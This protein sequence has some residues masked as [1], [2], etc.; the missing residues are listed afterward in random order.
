V[1]TWLRLGAAVARRPSLWR[2]AARQLR[3]TAPRGWYRRPPFLPVPS[4]DYLRF[5]LVTQ[6]GR[7]DQR[8]TTVD[9]LN[10]L[11]WCKRVDRTIRREVG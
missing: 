8:P 6:Y 7:P 5:R 3:R 1:T 11:A 2:T 9:V 10:Y 4:G